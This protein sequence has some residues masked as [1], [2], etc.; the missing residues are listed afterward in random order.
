MIISSRQRLA[1]IDDDPKISLDGI[2]MKRVKQANTLGIVIDEKLLWKNKIDEITTK[3]SRGIGM[4]RRMKAYVPQDTL[5]T[6]Y[7]ALIK[8]HL[9][10]CSL[11]W[12][13]CS[14]YI[15]EK[16]QKLQ[17]SAARV[18]TGKSYE[19]RSSEI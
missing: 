2:D 1:K 7:S 18:I 10:Y 13:N 11:V 6:V 12:D 17:N 8:P 4:L 3:V 5:R 9:D 14:K 16:L 15:L 19:T